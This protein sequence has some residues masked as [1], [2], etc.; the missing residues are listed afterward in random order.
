M[1]LSIPLSIHNR[2]ALLARALGT[3]EWQ[4]LPPSD[5]EVILLDDRSTEDLSEAYR[6]FLGRINLRHVFF[7]PTRH[8]IFRRRNPDWEPGRPE[9]WH[10]T[11]A[12]TTNAGA[13]LAR[14]P[15]LGL[16]HP[17][18]LHAPENFER[19]V[20][21]LDRRNVYLFGK[22]WLGTKEINRWLTEHPDWRER[23]WSDFFERSG[24]RR[25]PSFGPGELYWYCSF[26][27]KSVVEK[28]GGV[29]FE[30]LDGNSYED[31][32][33]RDRVVREGC[34]TEWDPRIQ[35]LHQDH[36]T[37]TERH[38]LRDEKWLE[39]ERRNRHLY[40]NRDYNRPQ[41]SAANGRFDWTARECV[42]RVVEYRVGSCDPVS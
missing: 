18:V 14:A 22:T 40:L 19:A 1:K 23:G 35:G 32:D 10:K 28:V 36:S 11:P 25:A 13:W 3:F 17:E 26:L 29:D 16:F 33:F 20:E 38:R 39:S 5:W 37:E 12:L 41:W 42:A 8:P 31:C 6:P 34:A 27:R 7:D 15:F 24:A 21:T 9:D 2:G 30:Y 4:T